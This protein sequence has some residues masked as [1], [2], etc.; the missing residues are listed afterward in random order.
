MITSWILYLLYK[1]I[2]F[3]TL[4]LA[5]LP[6]VSLPSNLTSAIA[7]AS[8]G[9]AI[10]DVAVPVATITA[11]LALVLI[12]ESGFFLYKTIRWIYSKI[13]GIN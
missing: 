6:D 1:F 13:P 8:S 4:P 11:I 9:L 10:I 7:Q 12:I 2:Y 5:L 3:I